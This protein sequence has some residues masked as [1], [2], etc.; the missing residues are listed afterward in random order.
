MSLID[1]PMYKLHRLQALGCFLLFSSLFSLLPTSTTF[2]LTDAEAAYIARRQL[3][4]LPPNDELPPEVEY[5]VKVSLTFSNQRLKK[6]YIGLQALKKAIYSDP[7]NKTGDWVGSNVCNY[8]GVFCSEALDDKSLTVVSGVDLNHADI[9]AHFPAEMGYMTDLALIHINSNRFCGIV[10]KTMSRL[11]LMY[12]FDI[13]N[14]RFVGPFP[15]VALSWPTIRFLDLRYNNFEGSIPPE[16][17]E[18]NLDALFLNNNRFKSTIPE[19][20]GKSTVSVVTFANNKFEGCIPHSIGKMSNLNEIIFMNNNLVGCFP[21]EVGMLTNVTIFDASSNAFTGSLPE[22]LTGMKSI[23]SLDL[24]HNKLTGT[25]PENVCKLPKLSNFT[26]SRNYFQNEPNACQ[27]PSK[28][29]IVFDD[30]Y[31]CLP[32]RPKQRL[33]EECQPVISQLIDC[34]KDKC[35]GGGGRSPHKPKHKPKPHP[36]PRPP[37]QPHPPTPVHHHPP[38]SL[39]KE[40]PKTPIKHAGKEE[41][42]PLERSRPPAPPIHPPP[43]SSPPPV[44]SP[45]PPVKPPPAPVYSPPPPAHSPPPPVKSPPPRPTEGIHLPP[46]LGFQYSSPPPPMFPGY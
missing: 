10:P 23:E 42:S 1:N 41:V 40:S 25:V 34:S 44:H 18:K 20:I 33:T 38:P 30:T 13:S 4:T 28:K 14:N 5:E 21:E 29:D 26:F 24:S 37:K 31:N 9:A 3:K 17:F 12:E 22:S 43:V 7:M 11:K 39:P 16:L 32:G 45:P 46:N 6:A 27:V 15:E 2:A 19:A 35:A 36:E 8:T